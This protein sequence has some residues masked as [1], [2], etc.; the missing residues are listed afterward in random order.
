METRSVNN[1]ENT[2]NGREQTQV[3]IIGAGIVGALNALQFA[4]RGLDVTIIDDLVNAKR[5]YKVGESLLIFSNPFLRQVGDLNEFCSNS[6]PKDGVWFAHG[7]EG[8]E[9]FEN[10]TEYA[11]TGKPNQ[12]WIDAMGKQFYSLMADDVQISR[13]EAE[14][15]LLENMQKHPNI[16]MITS[17]K[18][19]DVELNDQGLHKTS[20]K[21]SKASHLEEIYSSWVIDCSGRNRLLAKKLGHTA[22]QSEFDDGFKTSAVWAHF[23]NIDDEMFK[24]WA[25]HF[26]DGPS[27][28]RDRYTVH[29]WGH[30]YWIWVIRL[31]DGLVSIGVSYEQSLSPEG[32]TFEEKF[33]NVI[34]RYRIFDKTLSP[35][36]QIQL[37]GYKNVQILTDTYVSEK[38]YGIV[39]DAASV[40][41]AYYSQGISLALVT[42]WHICNIAE[43]D[44]KDNRLDKRY[45]DRVNEYTIQDWHLLRSCVKSKYSA[46]IEDSRFF[47]MSHLLDLW[48]LTCGNRARHYL[49]RWMLETNCGASDPGKNQRW[50]KKRAS[51]KVFYSAITPYIGILGPRR[52]AKLC[53]WLQDKMAE[54]AIWRIENGWK[55]PP[56]KNIIRF[57]SGLPKFGKVFSSKR[58]ELADITPKMIQAVEPK[59]MRITGKEKDP[60]MLRMAGSTILPFLFFY[61]YTRD[62]FSTLFLKLKSL[63]RSEQGVHRAR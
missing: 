32:K 4:K 60:I 56:A 44:I 57:Y 62:I 54:R 58:K 38:R 27:Q 30:G 21:D 28:H 20:Y 18:V 9:G 11:F 23:N 5:E 22:E 16:R 61:V 37:R 14:Q 49:I 43:N 48:I 47:L 39:G 25:M 36:N 59:F 8:A 40:V 1:E 63:M 53:Y 46:A 55:A 42:S 45:I 34:K 31:K 19:K 26:D 33:W 50:L 10:A 17:A 13:P 3:L 51:K 6:F 41:D 2:G 29:I 35:D 52:A 24:D 15:Q 12:R 7:L